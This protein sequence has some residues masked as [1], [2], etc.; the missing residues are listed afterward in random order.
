M[1]RRTREENLQAIE[2]VVRGRHEGVTMQEVA[3]AL[4]AAPP[5]RTLQYRLKTL[6][7]SGRLVME[8]SG[9][10]ARYRAPTLMLSESPDFLVL[11]EP[12]RPFVGA[13]PEKLAAEAQPL[14][15][16]GAE[17]LEYVRRPVAARQPVGYDPDFLFSYRPNESFY[18]S[19]DERAQ[20]REAGRASVGEQPAGTYAKQI[21][22][23]LLIDLSWNSS[24]LEGNT[25]SLLDTWRL[26]EAGEVAAG[27]DRRDAQMILNHK[28]AIEFLVDAAED[29]GF[30]RYTI[31]NLHAALADNLLPDPDAPGRLRRTGVGIHGSVFHPLD[32]PQL[33]EEC[34][35]RLLVSAAAID[36]PFEQAFFAMAQFPYLQAFDDVNKRVSRLA[37]NIPLIRANLAPL[38]FEDVPRDLYT[39]A[40]LGVYELRRVELLRDVFLWAYRRSAARYAA[41]RQSLGEPDPLRLRCRTELRE[42]VGEVV[43]GRMD[44]AQA[45]AHVEAWTA[46]HID[47]PDRGRFCEIAERELLSL[48]EGNFAR[49]RV[50]PSEF[51]AWQE[52][53]R[54]Q[55]VSP[56]GVPS[57]RRPFR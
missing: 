31:L 51:A 52:A 21:L 17:I 15:E 57:A 39:S 42:L 56:G 11:A 8:G 50:R 13:V 46:R 7:D 4:E 33:V 30:N 14:S 45:S 12:E 34:F 55:E 22:N 53:W 40:I 23:R 28:S 47:E 37:A 48:H 1:Q 44:K 5:R 35:D 19:E 3:A 49:Y 26:I 43:R 41:V 9:R 6:V 2:R 36:D 10:W 20:L 25:Y 54:D 27:K 18:L 32:A 24:R 16:A 29:I 38:S